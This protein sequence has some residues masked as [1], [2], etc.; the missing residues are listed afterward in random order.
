MGKA[1]KETKKSGTNR[2]NALKKIK[3]YKS[4]T[5]LLKKFKEEL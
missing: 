3:I 4:N 2:K 1:K 5:E